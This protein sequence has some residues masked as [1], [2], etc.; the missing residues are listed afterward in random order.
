MIKKYIDDIREKTSDMTVKEKTAYII[1]Y[2]WY[3]IL[4]TVFIIALIFLFTA[5]YCFGNKKPVFMCSIVNQNIDESQTGDMAESFAEK[6]DLPVSQVVIS[7]DYIFSYGNVILKN[8]NESSYEKFFFQWRNKEIDAVI[9]SESFYLYIKDM[10]G[11]FKELDKNA[12]GNCLPYIDND[13]CKA[14]VLGNDRFM[15]KIGMNEKLLLA[16]PEN[17]VN[18]EEGKMFLEFI[19]GGEFEKI[20]DR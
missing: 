12:L 14:V 20:Y 5:H 1:A 19:G 7:A 15:E 3:H 8:V 11:E 4:G 18:M 6:F 9:L 16:F 10:G 17:G 2:Y 13:A